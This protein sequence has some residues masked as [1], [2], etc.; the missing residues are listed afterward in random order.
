M[1]GAGTGGSGSSSGGAGTTDTLSAAQRIM[2]NLLVNNYHL[3]PRPS[4]TL[5]HKVFRETPAAAAA[6]ANG[7]SDSAASTGS[8]S[9]L[10]LLQVLSLSWSKG[11][12]YASI[13]QPGSSAAPLIT[14]PHGPSGT[15][16]LLSLL[17]T[18]FAPLWTRRAALAVA[19]GSS[20]RIDDMCTLRVGELREARPGSQPVLR[21]TVA[22]IF[23]DRGLPSPR[24]RLRR[25]WRDADAP[26]PD[27][28][29]AP[30][31]STAAATAKSASTT[32]PPSPP[33]WT[34]DRVLRQIWQDLGVPN[35][36]VHTV[37][38]GSGGAGASDAAR[39]AERREQ[40]V[41]L[42]LDTLRPR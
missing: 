25:G 1:P 18:R 37:V 27:Q 6:A 29:G 15:D 3:E 23:L 38:H 35:A 2:N 12:A 9:T 39:E 30:A 7:P 11:D 31:N 22:E 36:R 28:P 10:A 32:E 4:W 13:H 21:A 42:W 19:N 41:R 14:L 16:E 33:E 20:F 26:P 8:A 34:E 5:E 40:V 24:D 17:I